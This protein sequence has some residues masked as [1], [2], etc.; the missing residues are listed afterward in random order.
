MTLFIV[1]LVCVW[2]F[3][4]N[5]NVSR[6]LKRASFPVVTS[7]I[8]LSQVALVDSAGNMIQK[9]DEHSVDKVVEIRFNGQRTHLGSSTRYVPGSRLKFLRSSERDDFLV[10]P[11]N[12]KPIHVSGWSAIELT[13]GMVLI[14]GGYDQSGGLR[15]LDATWLADV[16][17]QSV[18][19]GPAMIQRR[20]EHSMVQI[21]DSVLVSGGCLMSSSEKLSS[22][23]M[24][25]L[26]A[27]SFQRAGNLKFPRSA[28][29]SVVLKNRQV[30]IVGGTTEP[31]LA[32]SENNLVA[33]IEKYD[34]VQM[35][36]KV[37]GR[38]SEAR[39]F[40]RLFP[41][42]QDQLLVLDGINDFPEAS[43]TIELL[44]AGLCVAD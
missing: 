41:Y 36:S 30:L 16:H 29:S 20:C 38:L 4:C 28:H 42:G 9:L 10:L 5:G 6:A 37:I 17:S 8:A 11:V 33:A 27:N 13:N 15:E 2:G 25:S 26:K 22:C 3:S 19:Q 24:Y 12:H 43:Q 21:D 39:E 40:P 31:A 32:D 35:E 44:N 23:E 7:V 1:G 18:R 34:P 14:S